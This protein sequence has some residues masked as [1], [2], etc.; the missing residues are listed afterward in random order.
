MIAPPAVGFYG[1]GAVHTDVH[2][3]AAPP[4]LGPEEWDPS[5]YA[6]HS[7]NSSYLPVTDMFLCLVFLLLICFV[8]K[9]IDFIRKQDILL[10]IFQ[11]LRSN[12]I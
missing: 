10:L 2:S 9:R 12:I 5:L 6:F 11:I 1:E 8:I 7:A 3:S 4:S